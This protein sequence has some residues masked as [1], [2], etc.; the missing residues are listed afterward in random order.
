MI[1]ATTQLAAVAL[2]QGA[3]ALE[4]VAAAA[5]AVGL[6]ALGTGIAQRSIGAAAVGAV[7]EDRDML[8][9]ALIFTALPET[10]IIIAFVTIFVAQG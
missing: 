1:D 3:P 9:P 10:L 8:V 5:I 6:G 2:Q 4:P 7:A